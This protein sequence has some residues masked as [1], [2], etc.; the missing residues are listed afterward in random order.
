MPETAPIVAGPRRGG[1]FLLGIAIIGVLGLACFLI[2]SVYQREIYNAKPHSSVSSQNPVQLSNVAAAKESVTATVTN[3]SAKDV[4]KIY[5]R[6][7]YKDSSG[8][9]R[10]ATQNID[11]AGNGGALKPGESRQI[12]LSDVPQN[13][14]GKPP[15]VRV[16]G[17]Q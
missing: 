10:T 15:Q 4:S 11:V 13:W 7:E 9:V 6:A 3:N 16:L 8:A 1:L 12:S 14:D 2:V 5:I 17:V